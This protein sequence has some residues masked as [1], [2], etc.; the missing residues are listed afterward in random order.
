MPVLSTASAFRYEPDVPIIVPG[1]NVAAHAPLIEHQRKQRG[2]KGFVLPQSNCT[3]VGMVIS[4]KPL[5]DAFGIERVIA[6]TM[7][8]M[9]GAGRSPRR[10]RAST[11]STT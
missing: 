10:H 11:S 4:L 5:L 6:T 1:V 9:S 3:V 8:S 2:W 7:Q